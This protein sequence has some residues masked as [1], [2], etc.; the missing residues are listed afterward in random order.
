MNIETTR[1]KRPGRQVVLDGLGLADVFTLTCERAPDKPFTMP[2]PADESQM[3][4]A[5]K[6]D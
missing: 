6:E 4:L 2:K 3:T 1:A 5:E